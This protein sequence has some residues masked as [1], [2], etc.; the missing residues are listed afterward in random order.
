MSRKSNQVSLEPYG[1]TLVDSQS[2]PPM[3][4]SESEVK[5]QAIQSNKIRNRIYSILLLLLV[6]GILVADFVYDAKSHVSS[7]ANNDPMYVARR[8]AVMQNARNAAADASATK[9]HEVA[10]KIV[11][12]ECT[13]FSVTY[14][15]PGGTSQKDV[16]MCPGNDSVDGFNGSPGDFIYLSAQ[17]SGRDYNN[18]TFTCE[19]DVDGKRAV[20]VQ[21][22]GF[23]NI[24]SCSGSIE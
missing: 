14:Q 8:Q 4:A 1:Y 11:V 16:M 23:A 17:N 10:Y 21:S 2:S 5:P 22:A 24:A 12:F 19:I 18:T 3:H 9:S 20:R 7:P 6:G 13:K 15:M